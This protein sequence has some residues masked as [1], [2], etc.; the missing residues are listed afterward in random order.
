[1]FASLGGQT[2][3]RFALRCM[4]TV[5]TKFLK[6]QFSY[7]GKGR[8]KTPFKFTRTNSLIFGKY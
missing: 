5:M 7:S 4:H 1:M 6:R 2:A 8:L 3:G